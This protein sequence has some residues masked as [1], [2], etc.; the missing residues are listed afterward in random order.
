MFA[1]RVSNVA[2]NN[3][4]TT[5]SCPTLLPPE[6]V[7]CS[8]RGN[9]TNEIT[10]SCEASWT[11]NGDFAFGSPSCDINIPAIQALW[12]ILACFQ[13]FELLFAIYFLKVKMGQTRLVSKVPIIMGILFVISASLLV[14]TAILRASDPVKRTIGTDIVTT[15]L[16]CLS[17]SI[18]WLGVHVFSLSFMET[19]NRQTMFFKQTNRSIISVR[20]LRITL[21]ISAIFAMS[22]CLAPLGMLTS[23]SSTTF[24]KYGATHYLGLGILILINGAFLV[25]RFSKTLR[26]ELEIV[27]KVNLEL[28]VVNQ[29]DSAITKLLWKVKR[30]DQELKRQVIPQLIFAFLFG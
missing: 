18:F 9:C 26:N 25:P 6:A 12:S 24:F 10:C 4:S 7:P 20:A 30:Y 22:F 11:G 13:I 17:T 16:F 21:F 1:N 5:T 3:N 27:V 19:A 15:V 28:K 29:K 8:G 2:T 23:N 14:I